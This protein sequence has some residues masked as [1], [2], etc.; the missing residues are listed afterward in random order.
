MPSQLR[1][2]GAGAGRKPAG[3]REAA[4]AQPDPD[5]GALCASGTGFGQGLGGAGRDQHRRRFLARRRFGPGDILGA[6]KTLEQIRQ[7]RVVAGESRPI[8][9]KLLGHQIVAMTARYAHP[10]PDAVKA[11]AM[12][13]ESIGEDLWADVEDE[14]E[15]Q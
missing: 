6:A 9:G 4:R 14:Y 7:Q 2:A 3:D 11:A 8:I 13:G 10:S 12:V 5:H 15:E 1:L